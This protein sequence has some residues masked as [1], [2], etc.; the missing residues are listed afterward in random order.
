[1]VRVMARVRIRF[2]V[3]VVN[4]SGQ[5]FIL[6]IQ[7]YAWVFTLTLTPFGMIYCTGVQGYAV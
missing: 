4:G 3:W 7:N 1:M 6:I 2:S 5:V